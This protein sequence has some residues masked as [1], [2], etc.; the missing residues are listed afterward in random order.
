MANP[1]DQTFARFSVKSF[2]R[3]RHGF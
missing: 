2:N 3:R 1:A